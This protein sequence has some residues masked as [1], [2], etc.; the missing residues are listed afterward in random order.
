MSVKER[1]TLK[2]IA[3]VNGVGG[4]TELQEENIKMFLQGAVY[5]WC[6]NCEGWFHA[7]DLVGGV[8]RNW[9]HTP[10]QVL[11]SRYIAAGHSERH[12]FDQAAKDLGR[13]LLRVLIDDEREFHT[14]S[15]EGDSRKYLFIRKDRCPLCKC[16]TEDGKYCVDCEETLSK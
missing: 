11:H 16:P 1:K 9:T 10:L 4:L 3:T 14:E 5:C 7:R 6:N 13:M 8:N 12:A 15:V 2:K